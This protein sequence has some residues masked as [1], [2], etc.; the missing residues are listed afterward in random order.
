MVPSLYFIDMLDNSV[1]SQ[2]T[3]RRVSG[4]S[5]LF[6]A[7]HGS[8]REEW[9]G[10]EGE[11]VADGGVVDGVVRIELSVSSPSALRDIRSSCI[12]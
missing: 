4:C 5:W 9:S 12:P 7:I 10:D 6:L 2:F 3:S 11:G 8:P 1:V